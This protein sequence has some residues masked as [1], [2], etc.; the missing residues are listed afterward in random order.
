M[1]SLKVSKLQV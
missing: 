1:I